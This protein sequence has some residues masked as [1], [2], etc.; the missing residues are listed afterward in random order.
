MIRIQKVIADA[1]ISSRR[2]AEQLLL[3][4]RIIVNGQVVSELGTKVDPDRDH[5][6]VDGKLIPNSQPK[7]Y[8]MLHK[9]Q[10][11]V[12]TLH[13][14]EGRKTIKDFF[15]T[16][17]LRLYPV[18]RLDF[19]TEGLILL[20]NDGDFAARLL[21]PRFHVPRTYVAKISGTLTDQ[22]IA[23]LKNGVMLDGEMT[24]PC[25][26]N[27]LKKLATN[28]WLEITLY[29]GRKRQIRRM[30]ETVGCSVI[31]LKRIG[32]GSL[33]IG[34]LAPGQSRPLE[35]E[36]LTQLRTSMEGTKKRSRPSDTH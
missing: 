1:G 30:M 28:S 18:G 5:I 9:P 33:R 7:V 26:I 25:R 21:H 29:E 3:Q 27:K 6:R 13:D 23:Q 32:F 24:A 35:H 8:M 14:P 36:E 19:N 15:R 10:G 2:A 17:S 31:R 34:T 22:S 12:S 11:C 20:T 4:G 16:S